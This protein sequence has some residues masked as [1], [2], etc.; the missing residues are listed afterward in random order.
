MLRYAPRGVYI[1]STGAL[2]A[3]SPRIDRQS[4]SFGTALLSLRQTA[5][6]A[7]QAG[8]SCPGTRQPLMAAASL[9]RAALLC[10]PFS[11]YQHDAA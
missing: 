10:H 9:D 1:A 6:Q 2:T 5:A 4:G 8:R 11:C 7:R 3:W